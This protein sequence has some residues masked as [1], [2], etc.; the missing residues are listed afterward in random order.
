MRG[1]VLAALDYLFL[2]RPVILIPGWV[3]LLLGYYEGRAWAGLP[4]CR[5]YPD[6]RL[7][8]SLGVVTTLL[9]GMYILNQICDRETDRLNRKLYLISEG[10]VPLSGAGVELVALDAAALALGWFFFSSA[11]F[12]LVLI[13]VAMGAAYSVRPV[14]LKGRAG[15]DIAA[16]GLGFGGI[17][18]T[19][20]WITGAPA[21]PVLLGRALPYVLAVG[22]IHTNAT[23]LDREGDRVGGDET[24]AVR[25]GVRRT[26][27]VGAALT[28]GA[29]A[30]ALTVGETVAVIWAAGSVAAFLWATWVGREDRSAVV[31][32]LSGRAF[33][34][35]EGLRF[36]Y[37]LLWLAVVY[38][39][40]KWYYRARFGL[41]YPSLG[42][43]RDERRTAVE[44]A[45]GV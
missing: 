23:V 35:L 25:L 1:G 28:A 31:N 3:F 24:V 2:M 13:S 16:N 40:T 34:V 29:L 30:A 10:R 42:D 43:S 18:F 8:L 5:W 14:R 39:G 11:Y 21:H 15:W 12:A 9:G 32:Q 44:P 41:D 45:A 22:A 38:L 26:L 36:P 19:L 17:V 4:V 7:L 33:V 27:L 6:G 20:G 37:F